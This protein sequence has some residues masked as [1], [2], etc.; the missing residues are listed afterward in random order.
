MS[1]E[2]GDII[3]DEAQSQ[4]K[5]FGFEAYAKTIADIIAKKK[6]KTPMVIGIYGPWGSGKTSLMQTVQTQLL[7]AKPS[8]THRRCKPVWF[9]AWKYAEEDA[10]LAALVEETI[11]TMQQGDFLKRRKKDLKILAK[12]LDTTKAFK[13]FSKFITGGAFDV[14]ELFK[15]L[16]HKERLGFYDTFR[17]FFEDLIWTYVSDGLGITGSGKNFDNTGVLVVFIDDLDRCPNPRILKILET[18]KLFM[19]IKGCVFVIG[20]AKDAIEKAIGETYGEEGAERFLDKIVQVT[21]TL[22]KIPETQIAE[23]CATLAPDDPVL[24]TYTPL[25]A[26]SVNHNLRA[27]KRFLNNL[28]LTKSLAINLELDLPQEALL[29]WNI[30]EYVFP[31]LAHMVKDHPNTIGTFQEKIGQIEQLGIKPEDWRQ[32]EATL[33]EKNV[34]IPDT[35]Q[36]FMSDANIIELVK[37]FPQDRPL[38]EQLISLSATAAVAT[39]VLEEE[40]RLDQR[41]LGKMVKIPQGEFLYG[42]EKTPTTIDHDYLMDVYPV[43]NKQYRQFMEAGGYEKEE[44]WPDEGMKWKKKGKR[45]Q[46]DSWGD[47]K[48][49]QPEY[50]VVG[51]TCFEA[52][53]FAKWAGKRLPTEPEWEKAARGTDGGEYPWGEEFDK[54]KCN[55]EESGIKG[56]TPVTKYVNGV[57]PFGCYDMAGNVWEWCASWYGNEQGGRRVVRGGSWDYGPVS[58]RSSYR[59]GLPAGDRNFDIGFRLA[60]DIP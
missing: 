25:L 19:D 44:F 60:Q 2:P 31:R 27:I 10:I 29:R 53:A 23:Y 22:P 17:A 26:R 11:K 15:E 52:E 49:N 21:F 5:E 4:A 12:R 43:T 20:A 28:S 45:V 9:Q 3:S 47:P 56:T 46:P 35:L 32:H 40:P 50:P 6:N 58:L 1:Y 59:I 37:G 41:G 51:V 18:I 8:K 33:Q 54:D 34:V 39:Q 13:L 14:T 57:S 24:H 38:I 7:E 16:P 30:L 55:S 42:D 48:W 36:G